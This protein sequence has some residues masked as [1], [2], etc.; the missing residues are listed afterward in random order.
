[1][2]L[3]IQ[4]EREIARAQAERRE[5][6]RLYVKPRPFY[7]CVN[8]MH[9][10]EAVGPFRE[11][12]T[13]LGVPVRVTPTPRAC[14]LRDCL[15]IESIEK[16]FSTLDTIARFTERYSV[17]AS[18][19]GTPWRGHSVIEVP[20]AAVERHIDQVLTQEVNAALRVLG[21]ELA[22]R[23]SD[24]PISHLRV[25]DDDAGRL[26]A[27]LFRRPVFTTGSSFSFA[28]NS[29]VTRTNDQQRQLNLQAINNLYVIDPG[30]LRPFQ[31]DLAHSHLEDAAGYLA[32]S[33][34]PLAVGSAG[35]A[36]G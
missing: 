2:S 18:L 24:L 32:A 1:M 15:R 10:T 14:F 31:A 27:G 17:N 5:P 20:D 7:E 6:R 16:Q 29:G 28:F 19:P 26:V 33:A 13:L 21:G 34:V 11:V 8:S 35:S 3:L 22:R 4:V 30:L 25:I 23:W 36:E 12:C 9:L